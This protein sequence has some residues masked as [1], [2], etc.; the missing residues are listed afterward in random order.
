MK[1]IVFDKPGDETVLHLGDAP[2]RSR[3]RP[4]CSSTSDVLPSIAP[5]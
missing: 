5:T 2:T 3:A 4:I 1:A